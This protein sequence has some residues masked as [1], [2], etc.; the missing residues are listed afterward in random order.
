ML[1]NQLSVCLWL[2]CVFDEFW[3]RHHSPPF[4]SKRILQHPLILKGNDP[5]HMTV[6]IL[7]TGQFA[8]IEL[9]LVSFIF[10]PF[11]VI[12]NCPLISV[13]SV[14]HQLVRRGKQE[15]PL[16]L[17]LLRRRQQ[18]RPFGV[19]PLELHVLLA[20]CSDILFAMHFWFNRHHTPTRGARVDLARPAVQMSEESPSRR[21]R[22]EPCGQRSCCFPSQTPT[23]TNR[24]SGSLPIRNEARRWW[25]LPIDLPRLMLF[26]FIF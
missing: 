18:P 6:G 9:P 4:R 14:E 7:T 5:T 11:Q 12:G 16:V 24:T 23:D 3:G 22:V 15:L 21:D 10:S 25:P 13:S 20:C 2:D 17:I 26:V 1:P 19:L 8:I